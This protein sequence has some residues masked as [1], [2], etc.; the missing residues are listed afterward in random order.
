MF[1]LV[2]ITLEL[3]GLFFLKRYPHY[4]KA[5]VIMTGDNQQFILRGQ[6]TVGQAYLLYIPAPLYKSSDGTLQ[7]NEDGYRGAKIP[8]R[9]KKN[10]L[11]IL[12]LGGSTTYGQYV[13]DPEKTYPEYVK[14]LLKKQL[15]KTIE[16]IEIINGGLVYGTSAELLTH[17][18]FKYRYYQPDLVV[19]NT[20]GNDS[21]AVVRNHYQPDYSHWRKPMIR[22]RPLRK[23]T[24][25][26]MKS[27][28][29][30][31]V[32]INLFFS[33]L[34]RINYFVSNETPLVS[35]YVNQEGQKVDQ[36]VVPDLELAFRANIRALVREIDADGSKVLLFAF[37]ANPFIHRLARHIKQIE[38][39]EEVLIRV[40]DE[41]QVNFAPFPKTVVSQENWVDH[42]HIN[43]K[44]SLQ[45][46]AH[47][48][49][50]V[51]FA[52]GI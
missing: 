9:R 5:R 50:Y 3:S 10:T 25:W 35:W 38:R 49:E 16:D 15:P 32:V 43:A 47:L 28:V 46:A 1:C 13:H 14:T 42:S 19:I 40:A 23:R 39:N 22:F 45:K 31:V 37:R 33:D 34:F 21:E 51:K 44:G 29:V 30:S 41:F 18:H 6:N 7:H 24:Q 17:Y 4:A 20:G 36:P 27:R 52:L 48:V 12:F 11:R 2:V 8:L 26:L